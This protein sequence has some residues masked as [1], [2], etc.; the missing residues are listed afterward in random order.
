MTL[1]RIRNM[2]VKKKKTIFGHS[3]N[4]QTKN[5]SHQPKQSFCIF[6]K[7][8][9]SKGTLAAFKG[10][11]SPGIIECELCSLRISTVLV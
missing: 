2:S 4:R 7:A 11:N 10:G 8:K 1:Q 5:H 3:I 6:S 9:G